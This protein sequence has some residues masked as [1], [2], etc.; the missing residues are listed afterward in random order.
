MQKRF[1]AE[2]ATQFQQHASL[3]DWDDVALM[4]MFQREL[5]DNVK[6]KLMRNSARHNNL[7]I[8]IKRAIDIDDKLYKHIMKKKHD[9]TYI[10]RAGIYTGKINQKNKKPY[11]KT[12]DSYEHKPMKL[13]VIEK[14]KS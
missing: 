14:V 5:K 6:D 3:A 4:T 11:Y 12:P 8:L 9:D 2:Y 10:S 7:N 13:D 1:Y